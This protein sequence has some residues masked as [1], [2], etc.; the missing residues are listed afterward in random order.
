MLKG[1]YDRASVEFLANLNEEPPLAPGDFPF[2]KETD[3]VTGAA[4][5]VTFL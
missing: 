1:R 5:I 4:L 2:A 3:T